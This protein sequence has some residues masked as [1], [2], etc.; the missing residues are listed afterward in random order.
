MCGTPPNRLGGIFGVV[1][2]VHGP[3]PQIVGH[4]VIGKPVVGAFGREMVGHPVHGNPGVALA[5]ATVGAPTPERPP[6]KPLLP[7]VS[8]ATPGFVGLAGEPVSA[9]AVP[10]R[11]KA[12][13]LNIP[14]ITATPATVLKFANRIVMHTLPVDLACHELTHDLAD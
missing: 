10:A 14:P 2:G 13:A 7:P 11:P 8:D 1:D 4:P 5:L 9:W 12:P 6:N 3:E